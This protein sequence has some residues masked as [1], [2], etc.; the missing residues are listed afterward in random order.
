MVDYKETGT[1]FINFL[2]S[3]PSPFHAVQEAKQLLEKAGFIEI[4]EHNKFILK[5]L[6]KYFLIRNGTSIIAF[7]LG[8]NYSKGS[9]FNII[10]AHT[11]SPC[12]KLKPIS[13]I[14]KH[15]YCAV[16]VQTYGGGLWH[17]WF[18]RDLKVAGRV[19][20]EGSSWS[21]RQALVHIDRP[22]FRIPTLAIH[23][24]RSVNQDGFKFNLE[25]HI[26]PIF[27]TSYKCGDNKD[28]LPQEELSKSYQ[29][30]FKHSATLLS[31]IAEALN[32]DVENI[33]DFELCLAD[34][35]PA[36]IGGLKDE[37]IFSA[38]LD[39]LTGC[40]TSLKALLNASR[41]ENLKNE[42]NVYLLAL[43]DNEE[44][45][46]NSAY[47]AAS[48]F[49]Q[50]TINRIGG[51]LN[52]EELG[53]S[54]ARSFLLSADMAH[55][56]HPQHPEAHEANHQPLLHHGPVIKFNS[57][58]RYATTAETAALIRNIAHKRNI[59]IQDFCV[60]NDS[61]CGSTIGPILATN[62]GI[63]TVDIGNPQLSMHSIREMCGLD[64]ITNAIN[65]FTAF[66]EEFS[67][68]EEILK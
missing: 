64:D 40:Y 50:Q 36:T 11:D 33:L 62:L 57:N 66:F 26:I 32:C 21:I 31:C 61:P 29:Q 9:G 17:T 5:S 55:A 15:N 25:N 63:R 35:Q 28:L 34:H 39:N 59:T 23:M 60:R 14:V 1:E 3:S 19:M 47:G 41:E 20:C 37:F 22:V 54:I 56:L 68:L 49:L 24:Q 7:A 58:Q 4:K 2:N 44:I 13:K 10:A 16:G 45:G 46:S 30:N 51:F 43:F 12:L 53:M 52:S 6:G 18:D 48:N 27:G 65:L 42:S 67:G 38:R 8:G